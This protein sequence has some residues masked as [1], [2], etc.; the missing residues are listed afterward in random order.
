MCIIY[1][2][3]FELLL[4]TLTNLVRLD[5]GDCN[6]RQPCIEKLVNRESGLRFEFINVKDCFSVDIGDIL[7]ISNNVDIFEFCPMLTYSCA[8]EWLEVM[9]SSS[10]LFMYP[11]S[12]EILEDYRSN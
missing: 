1:Y 10:N 7:Q 4:P 11:A 5:V 12:L 6:V 8:N 3:Q 2:W 9:E